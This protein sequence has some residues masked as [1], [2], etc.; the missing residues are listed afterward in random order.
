MMM[1]WW[2]WD[3]LA[4][5]VIIVAI[6]WPL[7]RRHHLSPLHVLVCE[8]EDTKINRYCKCRAPLPADSYF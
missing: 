2:Q 4:F 8:K 7:C 3:P 5:L 1:D 6:F